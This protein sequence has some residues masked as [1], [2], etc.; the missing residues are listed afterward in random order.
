MPRQALT[1]D[2]PSLSGRASAGLGAERHK[3]S[4][5]VRPLLQ[6]LSMGFHLDTDIVFG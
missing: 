4:F 2:Q 1:L 6:C 3:G 5:N